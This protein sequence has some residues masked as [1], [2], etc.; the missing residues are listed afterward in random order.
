[1]KIKNLCLSMRCVKKTLMFGDDKFEVYVIKDTPA[2]ISYRGMV[3]DNLFLEYY[4]NFEKK[5][6]LYHEL[7][8]Q[9]FLTSLKKFLNIFKYLSYEKSKHQEEFDA[10]FY[11]LKKTSKNAVIS[12][13][14]SSIELYE[15]EL[16][17]YDKK[18]HPSI[19]ERINNI[20][21]RYEDENLKESEEER[22]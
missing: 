15:K 12:F 7:Y 20:K 17:V 2:R 22:L 10:D 9:K 18:S 8:H 4:D 11:A 13:L 5:A 19:E 16:V 1:M 14:N 3:V 6:I 21:K